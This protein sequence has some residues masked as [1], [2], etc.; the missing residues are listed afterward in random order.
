MELAAAQK[1][2]Y[3]KRG[4]LLFERLL[5][6]DEVEVL[7]TA[8]PAL[9]AR[10][11]PEIVR[12]TPDVPPRLV[13]APHAL[14]PA[15]AALTRLPRI[16]RTV[17]QLIGD[18]AY[19]YQSRINLKLP[20][21]GDAWSWHQDY[22]AWYR[23]DGMPRPQAIMTA[24][25][26]HDCTPA[27]GPLLVIPESHTDE[28]SEVLAREA[29][30]EGYDVQRVTTEVIRELADRSGIEDLSAP[31][32]SVAFIHPTLMHGSAPN[33]TPWPRSICY[34][35]FN[36]VS[37]RTAAN[38]RPWFKNNTDSTPLD[39]VDDDALMAV[40]SGAAGTGAGAVAH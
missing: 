31:A 37:N 29:D 25:F 20:F 28:V 7:G 17:E 11:G 19:V 24:V 35:N 8:C 15:F 3:R 16:L 5:S 26:L 6:P 13:Y 12:D 23:G 27:N 30:V 2:T 18:R 34:I 9:L 40:A 36:A 32:G 14:D 39:T 10:D 33:L 22:S 38:K 21:T 1:D 4:Y